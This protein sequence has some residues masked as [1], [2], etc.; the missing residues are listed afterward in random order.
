M[1]TSLRAILLLILCLGSFASMAQSP[2]TR[3]VTGTVYDDKGTSL[4]GAGVVLKGTKLATSTNIDGKF[5]IAVPA[6]GGTLTISYIGTVAQEI[7]VGDKTVI[8]VNL[9]SS[10]NQLNDVVVI[11]YG[12]V[13]KSD[14]TSSI[15]SISEK[16]IK[17]LPVAGVDQALQGK[18]AGVTVSTNGGQPGGGVSVRV[19]GITSVN[20][21][22]PLYVI[23]GVPILTTTGSI[24]QDQL[25]GRAGSTTQSVMATMNPNDIA[26]VDILKDASAQAIY[27]SLAANGVVLITTKRGKAGAGKIAYDGYYGTQSVPKMLSI[28]DL[29]QYAAYYNSVVAEAATYGTTLNTIGEFANP[30]L[31]GK[32][33]DWQDAIYQTG[34]IQN[35]QLAFSGGH[36]KTTYYFSGNYFNQSGTIIG[37]G[38]QRF[39]SRINLDQQVNKWLKT[40]VSVNLSRTNQKIALTDGTE[41]PTSIV[42]YNSP[43]TP[44]RGTDGQ[45]LT[46]TSLGDNAFGSSNGNPIATA[47]LR[48][49]NAIQNKAFGNMYAEIQILKNLTLRNE[50]NF[51]F[52]MSQ[53]SAFQPEYTNSVTKQSVLSPSK[54]VEQ[55]NNSYFWGLRN[56]LTYNPTFN[57]HSINVVVGHETQ[58]SHYDNV[59]VGATD[60]NLNLPS[61]GAGT[62]NLASTS[63][64]KGD[65]SMESYLG[66]A[67]YTFDSR[68]SITGSLRRDASSSFG[69][70]S[71]V[72]Y[73]SAASAGWT[74]TNES[75]AKDIKALN[76]LK[77]RL[78]IGSVG[79]QNSPVQNAYS[80]N[81]RLFT[82][83]PF[84]PGGI[85]ANVGNPDLSWESVVTSNAGV[86]ATLFNNKL[87]LS[88]DVYTKKTT[89]MILSTTLPVFA[90]L[91][92][93]PPF[94]SYKEIEP[95]V[96]NAGEMTNKG[97]DVS[98]TTHNIEN[99]NF[100]WRTNVIFSHYKNKLVKLN[101]PGALLRGAAQDFT[102]NSSVVNITQAGG[103]VGTFYGYV[104]DGLFR[105]QADLTAVDYG[106]AVGPQGLYLGDVRYKDLNGDGKL[107][108]EDVTFIGDP[109]PKFT[110]G[111]TNTFKYKNLDFSFFL[112]GVYG[113]KI[114]NWTRKYT[115]SL[116]SV[117]LNQSTDVMNRY[118]PTNTGGTIPRYNQYTNNNLRNSDRFVESGSYLRV[119]NI[120]L[121]YNLPTNWLKKVKMASARLYVTVQNVYT[122]TKYSGYDPEVG[123]FNQSVLSQSVDNGKYPNPRTFNI[124]TNIEF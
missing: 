29:S 95:P 39:A 51:D 59:Q 111:M 66:R 108:S 113:S 49:V 60:L 122:F 10:A 61:T 52:Q 115:E 87:E 64:G 22:E 114:F 77:L 117:F 80:T 16:D 23:D 81:I 40:G 42:L 43:A 58:R 104:T 15:S 86:D 93:N 84:G 107:G 65:W 71:R 76:Y 56:Y 105:S 75:F 13:R 109:N 6:T 53:N 9:L 123:S 18:V 44:I 3:V 92:P 20:G 116:T 88:V 78:G 91:D 63:N 96:T 120:S 47:E 28:M 26:S 46:T 62:I 2:Q 101:A 12:S 90:G 69:P 106:Y 68:Y 38:F 37:S 89:D 1:N 85:P 5:S 33:T 100:N 4:P 102:G 7:N 32:G 17:N 97:I 36:D 118:T 73:F 99:K 98:F 35:H 94:T 112:Q 27:G 55:R 21:S 8:N 34:R 70:N 110:Y 54:L 119:Q 11:G 41:T 50:A 121:G 83:A 57:K 82:V 74:I 19:R 48:D 25:G 79:N 14:V 103:A 45:F 72:A 124:G 24:G 31:L 67:S 30:A